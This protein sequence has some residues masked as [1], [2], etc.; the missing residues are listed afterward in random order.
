[1]PAKLSRAAYGDMFGPTTG[2][3]VRLADTELFIEVEKD[4]TT[5]GEKVKL[6][7]GKV[8]GDDVSQFQSASNGR[9]GE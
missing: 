4:H 9:S 5:D 3:Q 6:G 7:G 1:M 2:D 8:V